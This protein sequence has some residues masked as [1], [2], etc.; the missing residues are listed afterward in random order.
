MLVH[1]L[2][3]MMT[4]GG[5]AKWNATFFLIFFYLFVYT[6]AARS[7][8]HANDTAEHTERAAVKIRKGN[9]VLAFA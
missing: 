1:K 7:Q 9:K 6:P 4:N 8:S 2:A 5:Y 3:T